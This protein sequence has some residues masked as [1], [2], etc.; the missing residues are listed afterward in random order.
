M[1]TLFLLVFVFASVNKPVNLPIIAGTSIILV[2][3]TRIPLSFVLKT[4]K[5]PIVFLIMMTPILALTS[6][7]SAALSFGF[8][9]IYSD[10]LVASGRICVKA[11]SMM[12]VFVAL[13]GTTR[14]HVTMKA[15]QSLR[16]PSSLLAIFLFTCRYI[17]L[18]IED[19]QKLFTAARLR[20]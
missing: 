20:G 8:I 11:L 12:L 5:A 18:Y 1:I 7:G 4:L 13:F 2:L 10:G 9:K 17:F 16:I 19:M 3:F 14:L 15:L 6:G